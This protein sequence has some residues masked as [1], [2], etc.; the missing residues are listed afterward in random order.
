MTRILIIAL[1][2]SLLS[3]SFGQAVLPKNSRGDVLPSSN[4]TDVNII[5]TCGDCHDVK[6]N[7]CSLHFNAGLSSPDPQAGQCLSCHPINRHPGNRLSFSTQR[8]SS[9]TC[10][11]CHSD[12]AVKIEKSVHGRPDKRPGDHPTCISCHA[13]YPHSSGNHIFKNHHKRQMH[14]CIRC[15]SDSERMNR[16]SISPNCVSSYEHSYHGEAFFHSKKNKAPTCIDCH[17]SHNIMSVNGKHIPTNSCIKCHTG[18]SK[19]FV[20]SGINHLQVSI[21]SNPILRTER[22]FFR[23]LTL[24]V[25]ICLTAMI[26]FDLRK[27]VFCK[28]C[29]PKSGKPAAVFIALSFYSLIAG[30]LITIYNQYSAKWAFLLW[31]VSSLAAIITYKIKTIHCSQKRPKRYY[32]RFSFCQRVQHILLA[33][34]FSLLALTGMP[35]RFPDIAWMQYINILFGGFDGARIAHR[36]GA[37]ILIS[38]FLFHCLYLVWKWKQSGFFFKSWSMWPTKS[39]LTDT[40]DTILFCVTSSR[41]RPKHDRFTFIEKFDYFAV[42]WGAPIMIFSG[43]LL[44]FP[45]QIGNHLPPIALSIALIA[46]SDEALLAVL[47]ILLWHFYN[48]HLNPDNFP[49]NSSWITGKLSD[50]DMEREH[51]KEKIRL[52]AKTRSDEY[53]LHS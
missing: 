29:N 2:L 32:Q 50:T 21:D 47:T 18:A 51:F 12:I 34:S 27:K 22:L 38:T 20:S 42:L 13:G 11:S 46:H 39:D 52:D 10:N 41:Q 16:Y 1:T 3:P 24:S 19:N 8:Q 45:V 36:I 53:N 26:T 23:I 40:I 25:M 43:L 30:M 9:E 37:L 33:S 5:R 48:V 17:N 6:T 49:G 15:H 14:I 7:A 44:W 4:D 31:G 35:L 28:H